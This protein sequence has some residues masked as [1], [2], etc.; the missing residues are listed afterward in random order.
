[1][2]NNTENLVSDLE[3]LNDKFI[4]KCA[5]F[6]NYKKRTL[7]EKK[8][9]YT[10]SK[11]DSISSILDLHNDFRIGIDMTPDE[12]DKETLSVF[13]SKFGSFLEANGIELV[14]TDEYDSDVHEVVNI[15]EDKKYKKPT[16][17]SV[18][19]NGYKLG[20]KI[21]RYPKVILSK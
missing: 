11:Y 13:M 15:I 9:I 6:E 4:R 20:T 12:R 5:D 7:V 16:I 2:D 8:D 21:I 3:L 17:I 18:I 19:S 14:P 10:K 1:M